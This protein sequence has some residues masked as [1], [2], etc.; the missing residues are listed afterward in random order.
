MIGEV[1]NPT[2]GRAIMERIDPTRQDLALT[3]S[4]ITTPLKR[5]AGRAVV[6]SLGLL[7][8]AAPAWLFADSLRYY[9]VQGDD[10]AY[11]GA[12]RT[13]ARTVENL[14]I[15]HNA[16]IVP[17]WRLLTWAFV[18]AAGNLATL[19]SVLGLAT[20]AVVPMMMLAIGLLVGRETRRATVGLVAM[21]F[22]GITSVLKSPSTWYSAGQT[23][24]AGLGILLTLLALQSWR[25]SGGSW[26][27]AL[28]ALFA[29][30]AG[31]FWTIGHASGLAGAAY[32][33]ADGRKNARRA[34][35][36]PLIASLVAVGVSFGLGARRIEVEV[37][38]EGKD[39]D[40]AMNPLRGASHTLQ[41][42]SETLVM[43]NLGVAAETS[44]L[45]AAVLTLALGGLWIWTFRH[46]GRPTPLEAAGAV[47][48]IVGYMVSWT[49]RGYYTWV[50]LRG[51]VPWYDAIPHLGAVLFVA[52]WWS[53]VWDATAKPTPLSWG[54]AIGVATLTMALLAVHEPRATRLFLGELPAMTKAETLAFP[55]VELQRMRCIYYAEI[56]QKRQREHF[57]RLDRAE[58]IAKQRGIGLDLIH[59]AFGRVLTPGLPPKAYDAAEMLDLPRRGRA[60]DRAAAR[61]WLAPWFL[62]SPEPPFP[63]EEVMRIGRRP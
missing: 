43:G 57:A 40:K 26:R 32:L 2:P 36:V 62:V 30:L 45:Q 51:V 12:S 7:V 3:L 11:V 53:R 29:V 63:L 56:L 37:R 48:V 20:F 1:L 5:P 44:P 60:T 33:L 9:R 15:P 16:H 19:P 61:E 38:F 4:T 18:A 39:S 28:A 23:L 17:A 8:L 50:N 24:W 10:F 14:F 47:I 52:G 55:V 27:L 41:S 58:A 59:A 21:A 34:A 31:G 22:A 25:R 13:L 42:I 49:F 46:G 35:L 54:G 6:I